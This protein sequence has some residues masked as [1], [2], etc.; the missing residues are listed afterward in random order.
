MNYSFQTVLSN[1]NYVP[2]TP[3]PQQDSCDLLMMGMVK[4]KAVK[5]G[6]STEKE[7]GKIENNIRMKFKLFALSEDV[8]KQRYLVFWPDNYNLKG[9]I[10][11]IENGKFV[12]HDLS[13]PLYEELAKKHTNP[14]GAD[15]DKRMEIYRSISEQKIQNLYESECLER[16]DHIIHVTSSGYIQP[17]PVDVFISRKKWY[18][19]HVTNYYNKACNAAI[20][21]IESAHALVRSSMLGDCEKPKKR[22]DIVHSEIFSIH[23]KISDDDPV[24]IGLI[25]AFSDSFIKYSIRPYNEAIR[26]EIPALK[27]LS[28]KHLLIPD[29]LSLAVLT[30]SS[31][32]FN[33]IIE[34]VR[35][36]KK[37][38]ENVKVFVK[39]FFKEIGLDFKTIKDNLIFLIQPSSIQIIMQIGKELGLSDEQLSLSKD[40]LYENGYLTSSAIPFMCKKIIDSSDLHPGQKIF[41]LGFASGVTISGML[42]EKM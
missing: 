10:K 3:I 18:D 20:S 41:C 21:A 14:N 25:S 35:Y 27:I 7:I 12:E 40:N 34:P 15:L 4:A 38:R 5:N 42:L 9:K 28:F 8:I 24:N 17:N 6:I 32:A 37:I 23:M 26:N 1:F 11:V 36:F 30:V 19:I 29:S 31:P 22:I 2:L 13:V 33:Y 16:P 39:E